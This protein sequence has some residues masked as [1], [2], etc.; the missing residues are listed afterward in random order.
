LHVG[1][2]D[3]Y[4][5][6]SPSRIAERAELLI[7]RLE[8]AAPQALIAVAEIVPQTDPAL[9]EDSARYNAEL[10]LRVQARRGRGEHLLVVD[11]FSGF[12]T[13]LLSDGV[14]PT[15]AGYEQMASAWYRA[16]APY[17]P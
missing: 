8:Q 6:E 2:N 3:I 14:H 11:Q 17:L 10:A 4:A 5:H 15:R 13:T 7:D 1:T 12:S 9:N 16:I